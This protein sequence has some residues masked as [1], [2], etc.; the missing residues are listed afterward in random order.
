MSGISALAEILYDILDA[1]NRSQQGKAIEREVLALER[2]VDGL[3]ESDPSVQRTGLGSLHRGD[4]DLIYL[5]SVIQLDALRVLAEAERE[6]GILRGTFRIL[7][8]ATE[9]VA[10]FQARTP[11]SSLR[12]WV[13]PSRGW[14]FLTSA[15]DEAAVD[16]FAS[17]LDARLDESEEPAHDANTRAAKS[18]TIVAASR[19]RRHR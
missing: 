5:S 2:L 7:E 15:P 3:I 12:G 11:T 10:R 6:I 16:A 18:P 4:A 9:D 1:A 13:F 17:L 19:S 8:P 14:V